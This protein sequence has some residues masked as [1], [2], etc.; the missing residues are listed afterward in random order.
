MESKTTILKLENI[1]KT[2]PGVKAVDNVS[3]DFY[4]GEIHALLGHNGAGK[5]TLL[6]IISG[7]QVKD[8][9]RI[10]LEG[11]TIELS[12]PKDGIKKGICMV[13]QE[14]DLIPDLSGDENIFL[15]QK[16]FLN[17]TGLINR[18]ERLTEA[19]NIIKRLADD[20][21]LSVP[22]RELSI[23]KQQLIAIAKA[24]SH[25]AKVMIFDEPTAALTE[26]ETHRLFEIMRRLADEGLAIIWIT[27]RLNEVFL[28]ADRVS[29]MR[30]GRLL[31]TDV[32]SHVNMADIVYVMTG[33][34]E[35]EINKIRQW[36]PCNGPVAIEVRNLTLNKAFYDISFDV[37]SGEVLGIT[38]L[39][40]CGATEIAKT[41]FAVFHQDSGEILIDG[42]PVKKLTPEKAV[43]L[44]IA[45]LPEDRKTSGLNL[46]STVANNISLTS[47]HNLSRLGFIDFSREASSVEA[48]IERLQIKVSSPRQLAGQ[49]S[50]GNQQKIVLAK[51]LLLGAR[52]FILCEPTRGIDIGVKREIHRIIRELAKQGSAVIVVSTEVEEIMNVSDRML[53]LYEG[54]QL[55]IVKTGEKTH[56]ELMNIIYG[57]S[58]E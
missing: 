37:R 50:G 17:K 54:H 30:E 15:G 11:R 56:S 23:S 10:I 8:S 40:G 2:F 42:N 45:Y 55:Q 35:E 44:G 28:L 43:K 36:K 33:E 3:L 41:I 31:S 19:N 14:L 13:Y 21:D 38:G 39:L 52:I 22:V 53:L 47:L 34:K 9:G 20:I 18:K 27:H 5:S 58:N 49:L 12:S 57:V 24:L 32:I 25:N 51:W 26:S 1:M 29:L 48:M 6:K 7:A 46:I 16:R 4:S